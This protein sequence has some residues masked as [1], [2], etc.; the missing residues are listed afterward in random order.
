MG[1]SRAQKAQRAAANAVSQQKAHAL[2]DQKLQALSPAKRAAGAQQIEAHRERMRRYRASQKQAL[3]QGTSADAY[4]YPNN[5]GK[6]ITLETAELLD[7]LETVVVH[8]SN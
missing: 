4:S 2:C 1:L 3:N 5:R 7:Q 6:Q 8:V